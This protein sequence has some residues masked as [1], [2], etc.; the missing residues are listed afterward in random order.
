MYSSKVSVSVIPP[1]ISKQ[2]SPGIQFEK[3]S[4]ILSMDSFDYISDNYLN[5]LSRD[6]PEL[7]QESGRSFGDF[8]RRSRNLK[9]IRINLWRN[10]GHLKNYLKTSMELFQDISLEKLLIEFSK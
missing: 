8:C 1:I 5:N 9:N 6:S 10:H 7:L 3:L 4:G 2:I